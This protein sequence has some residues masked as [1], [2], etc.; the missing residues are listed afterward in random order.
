MITGQCCL[1]NLPTTWASCFDSWESI[2]TPVSY[3]CATDVK[4]AAFCRAP[5]RGDTLPLMTQPKP[6]PARRLPFAFSHLDAS[7][8]REVVFLEATDTAQSTGILYLPPSGDPRTAI[9]LMHP[10]GDFSRHY[11]VP[12]LT[13]RGYG[14]FCQ[15]SRYL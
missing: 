1:R 5:A 9:Y 15:N 7:V 14:V 3:K 4:P 2:R 6:A 13:A 11:V 8:R 10:R 12:G